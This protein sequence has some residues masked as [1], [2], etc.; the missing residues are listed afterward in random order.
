MGDQPRAIDELVAGVTRG[1]PTQVLLGITGSGKTFTMA[2]VVQ[3]IQRPTLVIAHNKTLAHQLWMEFRSLFPDNAIHYF[4]S[5]YDYYQPEAYVPSTDTYIEKDSLIN[6]EIDRMRH[7]ATYALLTRRDVLIVASV[8]C[9][10]GIGAAEA[11][12][13]MKLDL[14][15]GVEVRRDAVLRR[16]VEIQYERNDVDFA[17]GTFRVRGDTVEIFPAYEREKAIRIEWFGDEIETISEVDPLRGKVLRKIDEVSIFPG[18][19]YVTPAERLTRAMTGIKDELRE[20]LAELKAGNKLVEEQRLAA[21]D[22]VRPRDAGADGA[23][24]GDRELLA[25]PVG[26]R[27]GRAAAH[28]ARLLPQGLPAVR[29]RVAPDGAA[30]RRR[31]TKATAR[32]RRR[33]S[34]SASACRRRSTTGRCASTSGRRARRRRSSCRR[35]RRSTSCSAARA[36]SSS[37]S[38]GPP[39][40]STR[41]SRC[42]RSAA[43]S[44]TCSP[45]SASGSR[46]A[47]ACWSR[48]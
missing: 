48:R 6:E 10:Y 18:S 47:S 5:Y 40:C 23:L 28:A 46:W 30:D 11:Y 43:R 13:G 1:D 24:Q 20:R 39:A 29:R 12:L 14:A 31:C 16:L 7:A 36:S 21:A 33:W 41:R 45:R 35:R 8:S 3:K 22:A 9:I 17:R 34:S 32:A 2:Q 38:S 25:P 15:K 27:A 26:A 4:V 19:H 37:R 42:A 44:T